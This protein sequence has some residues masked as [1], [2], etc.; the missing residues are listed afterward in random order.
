MAF[1]TSEDAL[2][3]TVLRGLQTEGALAAVP[4][5][6]EA[7]NGEPSL[8]LWGADAGG[9]AAARIVEELAA[10][11]NDLGEASGRRSEPDVVIHWDGLLVVVEAKYLSGNDR[12]Q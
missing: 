11:S 1:E 8:L 2:T 7:T 6:G 10:V 9:P 12:P 5:A 3:W 4:P